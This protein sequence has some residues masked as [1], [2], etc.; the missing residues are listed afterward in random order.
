M[1]H[2]KPCRDALPPDFIDAFTNC[3]L[4][5]LTVIGE[6]HLQHGMC[7]AHVDDIAMRAACGRRVVFA[8][9]RVAVGRRLLARERH[10][11]VL[12]IVSSKWLAKLAAG[13]AEQKWTGNVDAGGDQAHV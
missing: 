6:E 10:G 11:P 8:T 1:P 5:I 12:R 2:V 3:Q 13:R 4:A 7:A 9:I